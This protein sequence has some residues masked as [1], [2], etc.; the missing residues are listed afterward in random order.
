MAG[1]TLKGKGR[2]VSMINTREKRRRILRKKAEDSPIFLLLNEYERF[3]P[4][5]KSRRNGS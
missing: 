4:S 1:N 2:D 5:K 3:P